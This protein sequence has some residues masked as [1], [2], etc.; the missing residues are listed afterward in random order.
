MQIERLHREAPIIDPPIHLRVRPVFELLYKAQGQSRLI[1]PVQTIIE[2]QLVQYFCYALDD[3]FLGGDI[4]HEL[5][6]QR[7]V[8][9]TVRYV[10]GHIGLVLLFSDVQ[11]HPVVHAPVVPIILERARP[12]PASFHIHGV[13]A[14]CHDR[15]E[16]VERDHQKGHRYCFGKE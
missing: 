7:C 9:L 15:G 12:I 8:A 5:F 2:G 3:R 6:L 14:R 13:G 11:S 4:S 10:H 1:E 16:H